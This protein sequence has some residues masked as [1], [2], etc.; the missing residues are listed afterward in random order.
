MKIVSRNYTALFIWV[1]S[2]FW[3]I[4]LSSATVLLIRDGRPAGES[5]A[6]VTAYMTLFWG[7]GIALLVYTAKLPCVLVTLPNPRT[8]Q[9]KLRYPFRRVVHEAEL[10]SLT[11]AVIIQT[12]DSDGDPYFYVQL[13]IGY[14]LSDPVRIAEGTHA[15]CQRACEQFNR[16]LL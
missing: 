15:H 5:A 12:S 7:A 3:L 9:I 14:P 13:A 4:G 2:A 6:M 1:F 11:P 8:I 10:K 16:L